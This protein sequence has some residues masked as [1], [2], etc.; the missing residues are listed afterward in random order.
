MPQAV[1]FGGALG[2]IEILDEADAFDCEGAHIHQRVEEPPVLRREDRPG[3]VRVEADDAQRSPPRPH[4]DEQ[5]PRAGERIGASSCR[6]VVVEGPAGS[7]EIGFV[8]PV[9]GGYPARTVTASPWGRSRTVLTFSMA[10]IC[11]QVAQSTSSSV[12]HPASFREKP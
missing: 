3:P 7:G 12:P 2:P 10:A 1:R 9:L 5:P 6:A 8:Q 4:G 11:A